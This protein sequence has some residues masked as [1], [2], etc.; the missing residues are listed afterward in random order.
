MHIFRV[1]VLKRNS[2]LPV[3][4]FVGGHEAIA[5]PI[6]SRWVNSCSEAVS[7][8]ALEL[9][10]AHTSR[11]APALLHF[12]RLC[13]EPRGGAISSSACC[14]VCSG[15]P[16]LITERNCRCLYC[17][18]SAHAIRAVSGSVSRTVCHTA[19]CYGHTRYAGYS[20]SWTHIRTAKTGHSTTQYGL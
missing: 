5:D 4:S 13:A 7:Q 18:G 8:P 17:R 2:L 9:P 16:T 19:W 15:T 20:A 11:G 10:P 14:P 1:N 3:R 12:V 6:S